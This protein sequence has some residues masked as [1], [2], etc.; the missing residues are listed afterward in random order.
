MDRLE[1]PN[2]WSRRAKK[3]TI[4][5]KIAL[6]IMSIRATKK[7]AVFL[8]HYRDSKINGNMCFFLVC[9]W[10]WCQFHFIR[11]LFYGFPC[12]SQRC[13]RLLTPNVTSIRQHSHKDTH[14]HVN[15][16]TRVYIYAI[17]ITIIAY[18]FVYASPF[19]RFVD[20]VVRRRRC[21]RTAD[22]EFS[23]FWLE[24]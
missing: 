18:N 17:I 3:K 8:R 7:Y 12:Q 10:L 20:V 16:S 9:I 2:R 1:W 22:G 14:T 4:E 24:K 21:E 23:S 15:A 5:R 19:C 13:R 6:M 11:H